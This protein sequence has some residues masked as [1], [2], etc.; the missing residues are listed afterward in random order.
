MPA[1][2]PLALRQRIVDAYLSGETNRK[3]LSRRFVVSYSSV[4]SFIKQYQETGNLTPLPAS[5]GDRWSVDEKGIVFL[6]AIISQKPDLTLNEI[7]PLL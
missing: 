1:P 4:C 7:I 2:Y 3:A 6:E 5:N